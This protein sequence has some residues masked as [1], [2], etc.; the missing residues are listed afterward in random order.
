MGVEVSCL[1]PV[2]PFDVII[3]AIA[4]GDLY[5]FPVFNVAECDSL[6]P[7]EGGF[8]AVRSRRNLSV[9]RP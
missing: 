7:R 3:V 4:V 9:G 8:L 1:S 5:V 6:T 2:T